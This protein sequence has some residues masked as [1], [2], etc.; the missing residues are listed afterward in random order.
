MIRATL[1]I[2]SKGNAEAK[3]KQLQQNL[4]G[5]SKVKVGFPAGK[6]PGD[7]VSI[8]Y[9]NHEGTSRGIPPR[10]FITIAMFKARAELRAM[11]RV[12]AKKIVFAG[13][14]SPMRYALQRLG[15][16][17]QDVIQAQIGSN[18]PP[19]NAA[20][21]VKKKGSSKTLIDT[22]RLFQSVTWD[23]DK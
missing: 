12:E 14:S 21:T 8:A 22:G 19:A 18:M 13:N 20:S 15:M 1:S 16:K 9:W 23:F 17:G 6:A 10:P 4:R 2:Q 3:L 5:P 11:I 7:L